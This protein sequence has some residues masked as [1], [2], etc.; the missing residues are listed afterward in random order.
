MCCVERCRLC[1]SVIRRVA[2]EFVGEVGVRS[3]AAVLA[4][5]LINHHQ[6]SPMSCCRAWAHADLAARYDVS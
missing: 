3:A 2:V 5:E 4:A 1:V 6:T